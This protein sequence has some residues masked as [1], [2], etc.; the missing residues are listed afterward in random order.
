[1]QTGSPVT[2]LVQ[3]GHAVP[4][5]PPLNPP[6]GCMEAERHTLQ[7][8]GFSDA[9]IRTILAATCDTTHKVYNGRCESFIS[10]CSEKGQ[11]PVCTSVKHVLNFQ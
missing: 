9:A 8:K 3:Q 1:M 10:C 11:N 5:R 7:D 4:H 6:V 2:M